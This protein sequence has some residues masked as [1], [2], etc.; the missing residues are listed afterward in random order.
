M[1]KS[2]NSTIKKIQNVLGAEPDGIWRPKSQA[3]INAEIKKTAGAGNSTLQKIQSILGVD[4]D[5]FWGS[6]S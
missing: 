3:A 5:G 2:T 4:T 6:K 1:P